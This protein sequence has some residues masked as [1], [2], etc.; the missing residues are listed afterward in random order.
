M[1]ATVN[2][3][4]S[5]STSWLILRPILYIAFLFTASGILAYYFGAA[6]GFTAGLALI[7]AKPNI[8]FPTKEEWAQRR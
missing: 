8:C 5:H 6:V 3:N 7:I 1:K 4:T 2:G